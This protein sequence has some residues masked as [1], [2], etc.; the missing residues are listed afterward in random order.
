MSDVLRSP[1]Y[2]KAL[3]NPTAWTRHHM[4]KF[5]NFARAV[6]CVSL[7]RGQGGGGALAFSRIRPSGADKTELRNAVTAELDAVLDHV[8]SAHLL[9]SDP[10][11]SKPADAAAADISAGDWYV[12]VE[13]TDEPAGRQ[14]A[15]QRFGREAKVPGAEGIA[16]GTY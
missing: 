2:L 4:A 16:F 7:S 11:L 1:D 12:V 13:G 6:V 15:E 10:E 9:E 8:I 5:R 3:Q 14:L